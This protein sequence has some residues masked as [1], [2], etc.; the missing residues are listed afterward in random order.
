MN[1]NFPTKSR[2]GQIAK[3]NDG[4]DEI[5]EKKTKKSEK[6]IFDSRIFSDV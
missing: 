6:I 3:I 1:D 5:P 4:Y 2:F